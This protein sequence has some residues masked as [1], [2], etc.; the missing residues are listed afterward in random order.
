MNASVEA[1]PVAHRAQLAPVPAPEMVV[2]EGILD[3][4]G[5]VS[6]YHG[7]RL[8]GIRVAW[9]LVGPANAPVV[10]ALGGISANRRVFDS[11]EPRKGWWSEVVG[12]GQALDAAR[13]RVL[14]FDYLGG[15]AETTGPGRPALHAVPDTNSARTASASADGCT[16]AGRPASPDGHAL[17][18]G[19]TSAAPSQF[20]NISTYDQAELLVRLLNNLGLKS[21]RAIV[22]GSYGGM[23]ALA[24]GE[25]YPERV[26]RLVVIGAADRTHPMATAWRSVQRQILRF[27]VECGRP[28]DGLQLARS[29]AMSTYRSAEEFEARFNAAPTREGERF[30]FPVERYLNARGSDFAE[31]HQPESILCLSESIDLHRVDATRVFVPTTIVAI[32]EDQ[33]VPLTDLRG[34]AARLPVARLHEI[35][36]IYGHDAFLKESDQLRGIF[37]AALGGAA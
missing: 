5:E 28:K 34:L 9:R 23:V 26:S 33:L 31:R 11:E 32:R 15:S 29:L 35:S 14:S 18:D 16:S 22:G 3:V 36:S 7:G 30:T 25:R 20:P 17:S 37:A 19:A 21:L 8:T 10:C 12:P 24:F 6:L 1:L 13:F 27:A 4:P 2:R